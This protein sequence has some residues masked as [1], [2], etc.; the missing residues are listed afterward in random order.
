MR[1]GYALSSEE[2]APATLVAN[3]SRAEQAGFEFALISDHYHPWISRQGQ[4]GFVWSVLGAIA[5]STRKIRIGTGVTCPLIRIHP[6]I[7]AQA[8]ATTAALFRG[9]FFLGLGTGENLNE[10]VVGCRWPRAAERLEMMEEAI[11]VLRQLWSGEEISHAGRYFVVDEARIYSLPDKPP[12]IYLAASGPVAARLAASHA[13]GLI[14]TSPEKKIVAEFRRHSKRK[15]TYGQVTV[16]YA[17]SE[18]AA[19]RTVHEWWPQTA[20]QGDLTWEV[21]VP[22]LFEAACQSL[23]AEQVTED[24]PCGPDPQPFV[25]AI[26]KYA[27]AGYDHVYLH[28]IGPDQEGFFRFFEREIAPKL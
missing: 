20:L 5:E 27:A 22:S 8:A 13:D 24:M 6:A 23:T 21:K 9:R 25:R 26:R 4:S 12:A 17:R 7:L 18:R 2:H 19:R 11:T 10:H 16:C 28:Q 1:I 15:P 3:A 14:G